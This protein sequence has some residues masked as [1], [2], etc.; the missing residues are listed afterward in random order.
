[1]TIKP[2]PCSDLI[3][4]ALARTSNT[5]RPGESSI[6]IVD[7]LKR[8]KGM[9]ETGP[10]FFL[11]VSRPDPLVINAC[12]GTKEFHRQLFLGH[13]QAEDDHR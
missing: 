5:E 8:P 12:F 13:L 11:E 2:K 3:R 10:V 6:N 9:G 1:M 7:S 4:R